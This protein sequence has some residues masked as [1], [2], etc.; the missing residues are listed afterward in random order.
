MQYGYQH[1]KLGGG[2][3][4]EDHSIAGPS[5]GPVQSAQGQASDVIKAL[6]SSG[7]S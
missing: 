2:G 7:L 1:Q 6:V 3:G 5:A 4:G